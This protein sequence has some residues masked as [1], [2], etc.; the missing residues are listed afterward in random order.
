MKQGLSAF[1]RVFVSTVLLAGLLFAMRHHLPGVAATLM[2]TN[3]AIFFFAVLLFAINVCVLAVRLRLVFQ[4]EGLLIP[5]IRTAQLS[6]VGYF[7]NNF[8]PT[9]IGGDLV[10]AYYAY[11]QTDQAGK[12]FVAVFMDRFVGV[13]SFIVIAS[14]AL[15]CSWNMINSS[16]KSAIALFAVAGIVGMVVVLNSRVAG[17]VLGALSHLKLFNVGE[18][19]SKVYRMVHDYRNKK[20]LLAVAALVSAI[21]QCSYFIVIFL[22][23]A[24][25]GTGLSLRIIFLL[26]PLVSLIS[27]LPSIGGLGFREGAIVL[28]FKDFIGSDNA[29]AISILLLV[30]LLL[31]SV[32]G[33][34]FYAFAPQFK[35][36]KR[37]K[38]EG[39]V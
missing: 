24:S 22:L 20:K 37:M 25:L 18:K 6:F 30:I 7:F 15:L 19:L 13:F 31:T 21:V 34:G 2:K 38:L 11:A 16:I 9:A 29:F 33:A 10:K 1:L 39:N 27:M 28:L 36:K 5:Y 8:M 17:V 14:I 26:M 4:G 32:I 23:G 3:L 12:S 35:F